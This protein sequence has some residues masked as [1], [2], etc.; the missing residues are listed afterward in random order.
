MFDINRYVVITNGTNRKVIMPKAAGALKPP[1]LRTY[2]NF[3]NDDMVLR[4]LFFIRK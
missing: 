3:H 4:T 2:S 1:Q